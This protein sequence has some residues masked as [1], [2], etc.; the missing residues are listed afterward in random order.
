MLLPT[1][2]PFTFKIYSELDVTLFISNDCSSTTIL[3]VVTDSPT[4][5]LSI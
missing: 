5:K 3:G 4:L 1:T 2:L